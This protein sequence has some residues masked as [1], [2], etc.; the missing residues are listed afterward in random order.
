MGPGVYHFP[1][2]QLGSWEGIQVGGPLS[3]E[4]ACK[5]ILRLEPALD[6]L[7]LFKCPAKGFRW[8]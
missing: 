6:I 8:K 2:L 5:T 7:G 4:A 3:A 1:R